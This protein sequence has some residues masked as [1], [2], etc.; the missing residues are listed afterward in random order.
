MRKKKGRAAKQKRWEM[1]G[2]ERMRKFALLRIFEFTLS[3]YD[4]PKELTVHKANYEE[5]HDLEEREKPEEICVN[6]VREYF[7]DKRLTSFCFGRGLSILHEWLSP[8]IACQVCFANL[9]AT[10]F[11]S[12]WLFFIRLLRPFYIDTSRFRS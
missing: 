12:M 9:T 4:E 1:K 2:W 10:Y 11:E 7:P 8:Y 3:H 5:L 6:G